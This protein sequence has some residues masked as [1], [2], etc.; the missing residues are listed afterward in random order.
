MR[1]IILDGEVFLQIGETV[2]EIPFCAEVNI[3]Y[4]SDEASKP[5]PDDSNEPDPD[6]NKGPG[7]ETTCRLT[8]E[9]SKG[10]DSGEPSCPD[11]F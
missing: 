9:G 8:P 4:D 2:H 5:A 7:S 11:I 1:T 6:D 3:H 10:S